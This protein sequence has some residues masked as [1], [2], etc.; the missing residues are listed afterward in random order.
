[1]NLLPSKPVGYQPLDANLVSLAGLTYAAASFVKMTGANT[2]AL[3]TIGETKTDLSLNLVENTALS[4]WI[5]SANITTLG[6]IATGTW[7]GASISTTHTDAKCT[8]ATADNTATNETSHT[9]VVVDGDFSSNGILNRTGAGVYSILALGTDVQAYHANLAAIAAGTWTGA[10]SITTLGTIATGTWQSTDVGIAYGGTGQ[11]TAQAA[12]DALTAVS[13]A[14]NEHV[15]TKDTV[16]GNAIF[17]AAPDGGDAGAG[18]TLLFPLFY[19]SLTQGT[20]LFTADA[21]RYLN[22]NCYN[23]ENNDGDQINWKTYLNAGTYTLKFL[24]SKSA[25][26]GIVDLYID[27]AEVASFDAY[28]GITVKNLI[29]TQAGIVVA[30]SG[31]KD[32][33][34][35]IDGKNGASS[36]Y[37]INFVLIGFY[38]T[39]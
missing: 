14:T 25:A 1:M 29:G 2:F 22:Y 26:S 13:G 24:Y 10:N 5:G 37:Y 33:K 30:A 20:W 23:G 9:T 12:I 8:D 7:E 4:T 35:I 27:A 38:R 16:T 19:D 34:L 32:I 18:T 17:K 21:A 39:A 31:I 3:R 6:T 28:N 11:S 15:L 36:N